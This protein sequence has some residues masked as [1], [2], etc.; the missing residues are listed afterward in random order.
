MT[1]SGGATGA[2]ASGFV[3]ATA[4]HVDHG[5]STL[6]KALTGMEPDRWAEERRRGM[7]LDLGFAWTTLP[8]GRQVA[9]V[10]VPGHER[11]VP[12]M[13]AGVGPVPA[14][15]FVVAADEGWMPQS[16]EHLHALA[17]LG[18]QHALLVITKSD[19]ADATAA[20][21]A[22]RAAIAGT[23]LAG[24]ATV[25]VSAATGAGL[26]SLLACLDQML[27]DLPDA[28]PAAPVRLWLDRA[29]TI[30]G[31]G[32]VVTGTLGGGTVRAGD[33]FDLLPAGQRVVV[34]GVHSQDRA[35][36][37]V[38]PVS[39]VALNLRGV[40]APD[41]ARGNVLVTPGRFVG[42]STVDV[43]L[44]RTVEAAAELM[45]HVG[46]A[47]RPVRIRP[48]GGPIARCTIDVN[49]PWHVGDRI[50]LRDPG[51]HAVVAGA[52]VL[53]PIPPPLRRRG[54]ATR[55]A[56]E[57]AGTIGPSRPDELRR[58]RVVSAVQLRSL[59]VEIAPAEEVIPGW[60]ADPCHWR[61]LATRVV[62]LVQETDDVSGG[63]P[64]EQVRQLLSLPDGRLVR[65]LVGP[66]L[67]ISDGRVRRAD[68]D[69]PIDLLHRLQPILTQLDA[70]PW[71]AP[72]AAE[73]TAAGLTTR[74]LAAAVRTG[75]LERLANG[76]YLAAGAV[77]GA[78]EPLQRL[79]QPFTAAEAKR[80]WRTSRRVAVPLLE[81]LHARGVTRRT[82]D[83][84][85]QLR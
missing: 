41:L 5:K 65:A 68:S 63:F 37:Q 50:L 27:A 48:L 6:V 7:T 66:P 2:T 79:P 13:L 39:R 82:P 60:Y 11:F 43:R 38:G 23:S 22:A 85:H 24:A 1:E 28:D 70:S 73:L 40:A 36:A 81:T 77:A 14:V 4:G 46:S 57:L 47:A 34:R 15:L 25:A 18:V 74:E 83:G 20:T 19:L 3:V 69:L 44:D 53:D 51:A 31:A 26:G 52:T 49:L 45:L 55:R 35:R 54:A 72:E 42:S 76:L 80:A 29:F 62:E 58:R 10:D 32:T 17:A 67:V 56:A 33:E 59:G 21:A 9:F 75:R 16:T 84:R 71:A 30:T 64:I 78:A 8:S 12:T 61:R